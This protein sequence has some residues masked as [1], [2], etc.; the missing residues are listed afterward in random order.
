MILIIQGRSFLMTFSRCCSATFQEPSLLGK[1]S[2]HSVCLFF[3][4]F[5][6][7]HLCFVCLFGFFVCLFCKESESSS[8][9]CLDFF[10]FIS[11]VRPKQTV[12]KFNHAKFRV[13]QL[14][15]GKFSLH[16]S[17]LSFWFS[18]ILLCVDIATGQMQKLTKL[19]CISS[20][21]TL[22]S[23]DYRSLVSLPLYWNDFRKAKLN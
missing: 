19:R 21:S 20:T 11:C 3:S 12:F 18:K 6:L 23:L 1:T 17:C 22:I 5:P 9:F 13:G 14:G 8:Y 16:P 7:H 10:P 15:A 2:L 4:L